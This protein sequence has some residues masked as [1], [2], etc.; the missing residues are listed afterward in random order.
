[1]NGSSIWRS[2]SF[3][4]ATSHMSSVQRAGILTDQP[5]TVPGSD[6]HANYSDRHANYRA[7]TA[8]VDC[9]RGFADSREANRRLV[10]DIAGYAGMFR[11]H[12]ASGDTP[13]VPA[14]QH[15]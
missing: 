5:D 8:L 3:C 9:A 4:Y 13:V 6:R 14:Q 7:R 2:R 10:D 1:M 15:R 11:R 12:L